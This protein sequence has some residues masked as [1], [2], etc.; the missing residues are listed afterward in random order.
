MN[1]KDIIKEKISIFDVVSGYVRLEKS[2]SQYKGRCPFHNEKTP[3]FYVWPQRGSYH[4]FG[5]QAHGDIFSFIENMEHIPFYDAL[6]LLANRAGVDIS[7]NNTQKTS[8]LLPILEATNLHYQRNLQDSINAKKYLHDRGCDDN[9]INIFEIGFARNEWQALYNDLKKHNFKD[10]DILESGVVI[11]TDAGKIYDRFRGRIMFPIKN[12]SGAVIGF[13][14][15]VLPEFDDGKTGKYVNTPETPVYHKSKVLYNFYNAKN[16]VAKKREIV[17][18]EGQMDVVMS[19]KAG[20]D[21]VIAVSG[22]AFTE[23]H[24]SIISRL[25]DKVILAFDNDSAGLKARDRAAIMCSYGGLQVNSII[26]TGKDAADIVKEDPQNWVNIIA[27]NKP[28]VGIYAEEI[29]KLEPTHKI[30]FAKGIVVPF[31]KSIQSPLER[32]FNIQNF[33]RITDIDEQALKSEIEKYIPD[34]NLSNINNPQN[35]S[36]E[37]DTSSTNNIENKL[38]PGKE[39]L[40]TQIICLSKYLNK[41]LPEDIVK[42]VANS[43]EIPDE[44]MDIEIMK[45][46]RVHALTDD[47]L[48]DILKKYREIIFKEKLEELK[49]LGDIEGISKL[50]KQ[51]NTIN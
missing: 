25:A 19:T 51:K 23:E 12:I 27:K 34:N 24:V 3:S 47:Y 1:P 8:H 21:N 9:L 5:C 20:V 39:N 31:L 43:I 16:S 41:Q 35:T 26:S 7:Q 44:V 48:N 30:A 14:G 45:L 6:K 42:E 37:K 15:R 32:N 17:L 10:E 29:K 2:G 33:S 49:R 11:K 18:V 13:T 22:T 38:I 46:E 40:N 36:N 4:C 50:M 28:M